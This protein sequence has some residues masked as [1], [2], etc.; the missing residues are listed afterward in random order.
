MSRSCSLATLVLAVLGTAALGAA[1]Q[2][3]AG[4][5]AGAPR[6]LR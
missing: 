1:A 4:R 3:D 6:G 2:N 5:T